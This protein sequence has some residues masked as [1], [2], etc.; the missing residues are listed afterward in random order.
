MVI[1]AVFSFSLILLAWSPHVQSALI[2]PPRGAA[3]EGGP[4][5]QKII[6]FV[7]SNR[8]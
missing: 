2:R 6:R 1:Q 4:V 5:E 7:I 3:R 8:Q